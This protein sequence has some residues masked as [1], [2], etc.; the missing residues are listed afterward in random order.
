M[1]P[2]EVSV[3]LVLERNDS[4]KQDASSLSGKQDWLLS[5]WLLCCHNRVLE[6]MRWETGVLEVSVIST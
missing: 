5:M 1:T 4:P 3:A 6:L 2:V